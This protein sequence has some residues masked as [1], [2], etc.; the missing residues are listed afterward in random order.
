MEIAGVTLPAGSDLLL[1]LTSANR[2]AALFADADTLDPERRNARQ[3]LS[4]GIGIHTCIGAPLARLQ[5]KIIL[6]TLTGRF[7]DM[8]LV[9]GQE[10]RWVR[11]ISFRGPEVL[12]V[13][14]YG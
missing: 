4:F 8:T 13:R 10:E 7:P 12:R 11:T 1:A 5:L 14:P 6:E 9:D 2:D 3:H